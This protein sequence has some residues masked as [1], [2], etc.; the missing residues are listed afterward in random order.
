MDEILIG[1]LLER[2]GPAGAADID[3][4]LPM[5]ERLRRKNRYGETGG[6]YRVMSSTPSSISI[7]PRGNHSAP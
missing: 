6:S 3:R 2:E 1:G 5:Q 7:L 4:A